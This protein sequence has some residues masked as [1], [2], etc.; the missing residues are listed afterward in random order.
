[1]KN[2]RA[3]KLTKKGKRFIVIAVDEPYFMKAYTLIRKTEIAKET[4]T[5]D[6][7]I[8][9]GKLFKQHREIFESF[10]LDLL[11]N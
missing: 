3:E 8:E 9:Y 2:K 4:W 11:E 7:E 6:C 10:D 1:M 5:A